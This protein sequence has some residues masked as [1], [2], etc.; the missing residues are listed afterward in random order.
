MSG[1]QDYLP[2]RKFINKKEITGIMVRPPS[3]ICKWL[4]RLSELYGES[5]NKV[6]VAIL[7]KEMDNEK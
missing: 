3:E 1:L 5:V 2:K 7:Q 6:V 4:Q